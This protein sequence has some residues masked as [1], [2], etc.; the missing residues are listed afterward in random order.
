M[1]RPSVADDGERERQGRL[2]GVLLL[3]PFIA[4][5]AMVPA[6]AM[7]AGTAMTLAAACTIFG[8]AWALAI[9]V[10]L[11]GRSRIAELVALSGG[12]VALAAVLH[13]AG[14]VSSPLAVLALALPLEAYWIARKAKAAKLAGAMAALGLAISLPFSGIA[15]AE[16]ARS[17]FGWFAP[18]FYAATLWLRYGRGELASEREAVTPGLIPL[19]ELMPAV[20]ITMNKAGDVQAVSEQSNAIL[21][22]SPELLS[23]NELF[24]RVHVADR[25]HYLCALSKLRSGESAQKLSLRLR[26]PAGHAAGP[27][28]WF[29]MELLNAG[30]EAT[31]AVVRDGGEAAE[32]REALAQARE[33]MG[34]LE[35]AKGRFLAAVSHELRT[36][37]NAIIGFSD[38]LLHKEIS[39]PLSAKQAEQIALVREAG[40]HLLSVVNSILD[41]S[42]IE[43]GTY[44]ITPEPFDLGTAMGLC[45]SM[46][47]PQA[48]SK[49]VALSAKV[50][51]T[52]G[53]VVGDQRAVQQILLNLLSNAVKF[54]P[55]GGS[56][57]MN[58]V[59]TGETV[60]IHVSDTGIGIEECD[61]R[62]IGKPF[63]QVQNDYTRQ[64]QGT[65]LGLSLVKGLVKLHNGAMSIE[66]APGLGTTV[67]FSLPVAGKSRDIGPKP[68]AFEARQGH[69]GERDG[70]RLR[71]IA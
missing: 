67:T 71:K 22:L 21:G 43:S 13:L 48:N 6:L 15:S 35:I 62:E 54:T 59:Q 40:N 26:L 32:L 5:V 64:F 10:M 33:K 41:V 49:G 7:Q 24:Q 19:A 66:S 34:A 23:G 39:G 25:V 50:P 16:A 14:G 47:E 4:A 69:T 46:M 11:T 52:L 30:A 60:Q 58:A 56:V 42:K 3:S 37:L 68:A 38:M 57:A 18:I 17:A 20:T 36:P 29:D 53:E 27:Y 1:V 45:H 55:E 51:P 12:A 2:I 63:M 65:G 28:G 70:N 61:L 44:H 9:T 31:L 8:A